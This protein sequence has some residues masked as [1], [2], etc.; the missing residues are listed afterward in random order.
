VIP[1]AV[2]ESQLESSVANHNISVNHSAVSVGDDQWVDEWGFLH[3]HQAPSLDDKPLHSEQRKKSADQE[4]GK[5]SAFSNFIRKSMPLLGPE[6][7]GSQPVFQQMK[8]SEWISSQLE[9]GKW[10]ENTVRKLKQ[11]ILSDL[12]FPRSERIILWNNAILTWYIQNNVNP[13]PIASFDISNIGP[14]NARQI[15]VDVGR[16]FPYHSVFSLPEGLALLTSLLKSVCCIL[17][18]IGY[19]QGMNLLS[20]SFLIHCDYKLEDTLK[21]LNFYF[22]DMQMSKFFEPGMGTILRSLDWLKA[23]ITVRYPTVAKEIFDRHNIEISMFGIPYFLTFGAYNLP[24]AQLTRIWDA[25][26]NTALLFQTKSSNIEG[27]S[28]QDTSQEGRNLSPDNLFS[29]I[30]SFIFRFLLALIEEMGPWVLSSSN[31]PFEKILRAL[32]RPRLV[33][34]IDLSA[35][36][37][38]HIESTKTSSS[39]RANHGNLRQI[40]RRTFELEAEWKDIINKTSSYMSQAT[41]DTSSPKVVE[42]ETGAET[43][44]VPDDYIRQNNASSKA[45]EYTK[46]E[47]HKEEPEKEDLLISAT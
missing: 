43:E 26:F 16:T 27:I 39:R 31:K 33:W 6:D 5:E 25:C 47:E 13:R 41:T 46:I 20:A 7:D 15:E 34:D 44:T 3:R 1:G 9:V 40:L 21:I 19:V 18:E 17:P 45:S 29:P 8:N 10:D 36:S 30:T 2:V 35:Q 24:F 11:L 42:G 4:D 23:A 28:N 12:S 32:Q 37:T 38:K 22:H 14:A